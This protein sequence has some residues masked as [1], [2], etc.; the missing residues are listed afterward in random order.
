LADVVLACLGEK[1]VG[2]AVTNTRLALRKRRGGR[3]GEE[4]PFTTRVVEL[5]TDQHGEA[6]TTLAID[7]SSAIAP[8]AAKTKPWSKSLRL[9]QRCLSTALIELG[10][11]QRPN[12]DGPIVT[13]VDREAVRHEFSNNY[14]AEGTVEQ[15]KD[16]TRKAFV[17]AINEAQGSSLIGVR[18]TGDK[19]VIWMVQET[20]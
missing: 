20:E 9:F 13:A 10:T 6:V 3:N 14:P 8:P 11:Q 12:A 15:K 16:A 1:T 4:F 5:G 7:W 19:T 2:G 18:N 17:R